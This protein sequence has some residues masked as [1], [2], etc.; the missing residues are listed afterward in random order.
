MSE[1]V[2]TKVYGTADS[3]HTVIDTAPKLSAADNKKDKIGLIKQ[4]IHIMLTNVY[5]YVLL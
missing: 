5:H 3:I 1:D 4:Y 2:L